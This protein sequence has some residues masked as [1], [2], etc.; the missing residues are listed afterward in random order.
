MVTP[1]NCYVITTIKT[2]QKEFVAFRQQSANKSNK[3]LSN[4]VFWFNLLILVSIITINFLLRKFME[5]LS[6]Y[7][8]RKFYTELE[9]SKILKISMLL[10]MNIAFVLLVTTIILGLQGQIEEKFGELFGDQGVIFSIQLIMVSSLTTPIIWSFFNPEHL[11]LHLHYLWARRKCSKSSNN[12]YIQEEL[13]F[14]FQRFDFEIDFKY[15]MIFKTVSISFFF[16][17]IIPMGLVVALFE[18]CLYFIF[19]KHI[20]LARCERPKDMDFNLTENVLKIFDKCLL[21]IPL[22]HLVFFKL[23]FNKQNNQPVFWI[24]MLMT[25]IEAF[26]ISWREVFRCCKKAGLEKESIPEFKDIEH[27]VLKYTDINPAE[28]E[29]NF[30]ATLK[31]NRIISTQL[32]NISH[33]PVSQNVSIYSRHNPSFKRFGNHQNDHQ[34]PGTLL[35]MPDHPTDHS[36]TNDAM[37]LSL[38][39]SVNPGRKRRFMNAPKQQTHTDNRHDQEKIDL[40]N[41]YERHIEE[42]EPS[43]RRL[44]QRFSRGMSRGLSRGNSQGVQSVLGPSNDYSIKEISKIYE[45]NVLMMSRMKG[46]NRNMKHI[47]TNRGVDYRTSIS[48]IPRMGSTDQRSKLNSFFEKHENEEFKLSVPKNTK[49]NGSQSKIKKF[50]FEEVGIWNVC[51]DQCCYYYFYYY[52][53]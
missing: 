47:E 22:G 20:L 44:S 1:V 48:R 40:I 11:M 26:I 52:Y 7:E 49:A 30:S 23:Y 3:D 28:S 38:V 15:Y 45:K 39:H 10:F 6:F 25:F 19:D 21:L 9:V 34:P 12:R 46:F 16:L 31:S 41:K 2:K 4:W 24:S 14:I 35:D 5:F 50:D 53:Y 18:I 29:I 37:F 32:S 27:T 17:L 33:F 51:L 43:M 8:N 36:E 13:N 42:K